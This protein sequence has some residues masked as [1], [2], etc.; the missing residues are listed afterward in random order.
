M[1]KVIFSLVVLA[2]S[3]GQLFASERLN[4]LTETFRNV[5]GSIESTDA[6][7]QS[8]LDN[9]SGWTFTNVY[10]GPE[11][12]IIKKGGSIT[13]PVVPELIGNVAFSFDAQWWEDPN[14][15]PEEEP[16][17]APHALS[18]IGK[19]ELS[20][21]EYDTMTSHMGAEVIYDA[22][23]TT[24]LT[25]TASYDIMM[26]NVCIY[27][28][29]NLNADTFRDDY[30]KFSPEG[31]EFF[32]PFDLT[33]T[34]STVGLSGDDGMHNILVYTTDGTDPVRTSTRY[35]G[36]PIHISSNTTVK[37]ATIFGDGYMYHDTPRTYT[38]L[39]QGTPE[40]EIP[41]NT[42]ELTVSKPGNLKAQ[43]LEVDADI[44][45]GLVLK[46]KINGADLK[47]LIGEEGRTASLSYL[48]MSD[49]TFEY[50][51]TEYRTVVYAPEAGMGTTTV[52]HYFLSTENY[53]TGIG[54]SPT[55]VQSN[56][57]RNNL[58]VAFIGHKSI[59]SVVL[60]SSLT[61][62]GGQMFE[63]CKELTH[64]HLNEGMT[65]IGGSAFSGCEKLSYINFPESLTF[66]GGGALAGCVNLVIPV[67]PTTFEE[68]GD[69]AFIGT[70]IGT[71]KFDK[72]V[73]FGEEAFS[74]TTVEKFEMLAPTDSIPSGAFAECTKLEE[75]TIGEGLKYI[76]YHAF[77]DS[78][79]KTANLPQSIEEIGDKAFY[80]CPFFTNLQ[81][82]DGIRYIGKVAYEVV[83][84][85]RQEYT[86]KP[87]TVSL[88]P[89]LFYA[90]SATTINLP[91][92][93]EIIGAGAFTGTQITSIPSLPAL[94]VIGVNA[95]MGSQIMGIPDLPS[96]K[97]IEGGAFSY[98]NNLARVTIPESVEFIGSNAF[99][100]CNALWSV[101]YNAINAECEGR[102][103]PR[104]LE[105]IVIG[106][107]VRRLPAGL[108]TGNTNVTEIILPKSVEI[109]DPNVFENCVNLEYV[110][111]SDNITTISNNAFYGC[112]SL[113]DLHW[114]A[115][116]KV[117]GS[118]AF[119][120]CT[121]LKTVSLPE[122]VEI[123]GYYA[124]F[125]CT[126]V[127]NL[128]IASTIKEFGQSCFVIETLGN[129]VPP[130]TITASAKTPQDIDWNWHYIGIP[131]IKVPA[132]SLTAYQN[133]PNW[134]GSRNG[135]NNVIIPIEGITASEEKTETTFD[136]GIDSD[137]DLGDTVIGD[138]YLTLG[139]EDG[140]DE[141]DGAIV[142]NSS[143]DEE[144]V[145][146][147]GGMAPGESDLANRFN[148]LVVQI[149][150]GTGKITINCMT[151]GSKRVSVKIGDDEPLYYTKDSKGDITIDYNVS[152]DTYVYIY[153]SE[154]EAQQQSIHRARA[155]STGNSVKIYSIGVNPETVGI[156]EIVVD[157]EELSPITEYYR[158]D[159]TRIMTPTT[160]GIYIA[161]HANG[162]S[163]KILVK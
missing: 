55:V 98:C 107:K 27:Y 105:R 128:Y 12:I 14:R 43:L 90:S 57:Y 94:R 69:G 115:R 24:R 109:L 75:I 99:Q 64:V 80:G 97:V 112:S 150:A 111:L 52:L 66:V 4:L 47:Y 157:N 82:E 51:D 151:I 72:P 42:F 29:G 117:I 41:A 113:T 137:T 17:W 1:K 74:R 89:D 77:Y 142:L 2:I 60:P 50:D 44:I 114:P 159:G 86:V 110:R 83:D 126:G 146:A 26:T 40:I 18:L 91:E 38:F 136:S 148:G 163:S 160:P 53:D 67:L 34:K 139:E 143:M 16:S 130:I 30:T 32:N 54:G 154:P 123:V 63:N 129:P 118:N 132:A 106:D 158:I 7:D 79:V 145:E 133:N 127:E 37:T 141:T 10:A 131:T 46:G 11:C 15:N 22:D 68:I 78:N 108:Y 103:S 8:E 28:A 124:F 87:G 93:L 116:L 33:L 76:G 134:N 35:E 56:V 49:L 125:G 71:I 92:S 85:K 48:D 95:F 152:E 13:T 102:L 144:Y 149:P 62:V 45:E 138:V 156:E 9:P 162:K 6:L 81:P 121:S 135:K 20:T 25:L 3:V 39:T 70:K 59:K 122:G 120:Y 119:E 65:S 104:D 31:G 155:A 161:R 101:T 5:N 36:T 61:N 140:Y 58:A 100:G 153:A 96:L 147:I 23:G 88:T 19:G 73:K 84:D 21:D